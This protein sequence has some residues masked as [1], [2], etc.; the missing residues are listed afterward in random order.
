MQITQSQFWSF[1][2]VGNIHRNIDLV[3]NH[4]T[5]QLMVRRISAPEDYPV[6]KA[7]CGIRH[8]NLM[9]VYSVRIKDGVCVSLCEFINGVTLA[10]L[11]ENNGTYRIQPA[12]NIICQICDGLTVLHQHGMVH[13]DIKPENV[14]LDKSGRVKIIDFSISRLMKPEKR[15]DTNVLGTAGYAS[16]E[17]FGFGQTNGR[18]DIYACG[19]LLNYLLTGK[20]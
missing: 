3:R 11:V 16:P 15:K 7:L 19:V 18:A 1:S 13:R 5:G 14:M 17:Q 10:F 2:V 12:K 6:M 20:V 9:S 8:P 4:A